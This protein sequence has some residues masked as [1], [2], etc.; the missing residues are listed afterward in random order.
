MPSMRK[1]IGLTVC[2]WAAHVAATPNPYACNADNCLRALRGLASKSYDRVS[3]DCSKYVWTTATGAPATVTETSTIIQT[4]TAETTESVTIT[5]YETVTSTAGASTILIKEPNPDPHAVAKARG[6]SPR[7]ATSPVPTYASACTSGAR[8]ASACSCFG[9][10][11]S[12][13]TVDPSTVTVFEHTTTVIT[14]T[15]T[16]LSSTTVVETST[17]TVGG[18]AVEYTAF[19][20]AVVATG[21][22]FPTE[23]NDAGETKLYAGSDGPYAWFV[24]SHP[25]LPVIRQPDG[26]IYIPRY[27]QRAYYYC[28]Q[29]YDDWYEVNLPGAMTFSVSWSGVFGTEGV[30]AYC[31]WGADKIIHCSCTVNGVL[32]DKMS[33]RE[34]RSGYSEITLRSGAIPANLAEAEITAVAITAQNCGDSTPGWMGCQ[35]W[36]NP[37]D[38]PP[39]TQQTKKRSLIFNKS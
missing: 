17:S 12:V 8:Y 35:G 1:F 7:D 29:A 21:P 4:E 9:V 20:M 23:W 32:Y 26:K 24:R 13:A 3:T 11:A 10:P 22:N 37:N 34:D 36:T 31:N 15:S 28:R 30:E 33:Y 5:S 6:L 39:W 27:G 18:D 19:A 38:T 25:L 14:T 16:D 2:A